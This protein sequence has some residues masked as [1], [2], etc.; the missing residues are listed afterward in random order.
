M[1]VVLLVIS[2]L[3]IVIVLL[4]SAKAEGAAQI[5]SGSTSDLFTN[6]KERGSELFISRLTLFLGLAFFGICLVSMFIK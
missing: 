4:Q 6:R 2:I 3:L 1:E 5:I